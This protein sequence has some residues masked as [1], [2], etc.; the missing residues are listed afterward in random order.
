[1]VRKAINAEG[2]L[3]VGPYSPAVEA[4][5]T[6]YLSA[7]TP[8]V[9]ETGKLVEGGITVQTEQV[10]Q[11][12]FNI[13]SAAGLS[14]DH[15][16]KVTVYLTDMGNFTAMNSVYAKQFKPPH[17]ARTTVGVRELPLGALVVMEL[18]AIRQ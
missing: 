14:A 6:I 10:F 16:V 15:V 8:V 4:G 17:P 3:S 9:P 7:Q 1:M 18:I 13:L 5:N 11:N 12:M 2:T